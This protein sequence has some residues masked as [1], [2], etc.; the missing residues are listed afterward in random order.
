VNPDQCVVNVTLR[1]G[2]AAAVPATAMAV[3]ATDGLKVTVTITNGAA[4]SDFDFF[5]TVDQIFKV[6]PVT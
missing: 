1:Q 4:L 3:V 5:I 2:V 6:G